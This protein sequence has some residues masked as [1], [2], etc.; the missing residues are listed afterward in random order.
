V[1]EPPGIF[2]ELARRA[3]AL[4]NRTLVS[5]ESAG[6]A[7]VLAVLAWAP[8]RVS[9]AL[10]FV[11][12]SMFGLWGVTDHARR[13]RDPLAPRTADFLLACIQATAATIG[14]LAVAAVIF[15]LAGLMIGTVVS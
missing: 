2:Q 4:S 11:A 15:A 5:L 9:I 14:T 8:Q 3:N 10:P 12:M 1:S 13:S 7:A 6:L